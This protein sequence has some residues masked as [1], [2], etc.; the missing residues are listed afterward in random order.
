MIY[1]AVHRQLNENENRKQVY[2]SGLLSLSSYQISLIEN[3]SNIRIKPIEKFS[4]FE[5]ISYLIP[6]QIMFTNSLS[7]IVRISSS[8]D[9]LLSMRVSFHRGK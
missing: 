7:V 1:V 2:K 9:S 4:I 5:L 3:L 6:N 8:I